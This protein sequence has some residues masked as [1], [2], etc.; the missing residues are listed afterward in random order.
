[1]SE[2]KYNMSF[3]TGGL[4]HVESI[5]LAQMFV[6]TND[7]E[8][9]RENVLLNNLLQSRTVNTSKRNFREIASRLKCLSRDYLSLLIE[10]NHQDQGYILWIA[11]CRRYRFIAEFAAE[12]I[13]ERYISLKNDLS[14]EE[15]DYFFN[16][17]AQ[18]HSELDK[19]SSTT[20]LK[21][22]QVL[23]KMLREADLLA[24]NNTI[25]AAMVSSTLL[26]LMSH[27]QRQDI[28]YFPVFESD[29]RGKS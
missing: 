11:V 4:F 16:K 6:E 29:L 28:L 22:R 23:F 25:N 27:D 20:R 14:Y 19:I 12:V 15:F 2:D 18:W 7:W 24:G 1:M 26:K 3:T 17:K 10:S 8:I 13:R 5:K 9:V 21:L